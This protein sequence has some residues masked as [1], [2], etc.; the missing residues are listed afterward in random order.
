MFADD[1]FDGEGPAV[2]DED[3]DN[4]GFLDTEDDFPL[5][6]S[7]WL[8]TDGDT[9]GDLSDTDDDNDGVLD[10]DELAT[11]TDP[12]VVDSDGD[13]ICDG[14]YPERSLYSR[15]RSISD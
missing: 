10:S 7:D 12:T 3:D 14:P 4:D 6:P 5:D 15:A 9:V 2:A 8:D 11:G 1:D 13:G